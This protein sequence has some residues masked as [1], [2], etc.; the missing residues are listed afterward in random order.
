M[1]FKLSRS[2]DNL[3]TPGWG[4]APLSFHQRL[5]EKSSSLQG[6]T[7]SQNHR[8]D[9]SFP[10]PDE[11]ERFL[12]GNAALNLEKSDSKVFEA[13]N[14]SAQSLTDWEEMKNQLKKDHQVITR[15]V[16]NRKRSETNDPSGLDG[17]EHFYFKPNSSRKDAESALQGCPEG[18]LS[19]VLIVKFQQLFLEIEHLYG[20]YRI[21]KILI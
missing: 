4:E 20:Q 15:R 13:A 3:P 17:S 9:S 19:T 16:S 12:Y 10:V 5:N 2:D 11:L 1:K 6:H 8:D 7:K 18:Q 21:V 14:E